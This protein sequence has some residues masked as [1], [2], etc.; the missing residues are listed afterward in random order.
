MKGPSSSCLAPDRS[1]LLMCQTE[2]M[3]AMRLAVLTVL[4]TASACGG[5]SQAAEPF[6]AIVD[7]VPLITPDPSGTFAVVSVSTTVD[8]VCAVAY[9]E[10]TELGRL[11][12]DLDMAG[13]GHVDHSARLTGLTPDSLYYYR[14]QGVGPD[15][16]LFQSDLMEFRT[17]PA[18]AT[19]RNNVAPTGLVVDVSSEFS[20][21]FAAR[22]AIDGDP[23]TEWS[24][25]GDG[26]GAF[27]VIDLG[28]E[29]DIVGVAFRARTMSDGSAITNTF[30][31]IVDEGSP[32]GPF[33]AGEAELAVTGRVVR[34]D[35]ESSTGGN[36]GAAE[37]EIYTNR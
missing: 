26:D 23:G 11:A 20:T 31:V 5:S 27:I 13:G 3:R 24:S 25:Q 12:T 33:A 10:T 6:S 30:S 16:T 21:A 36:T 14:L 9:G 29:T 19:D 28:V 18:Q 32:L 15:G 7:G 2:P 34:F 17:P 1:T 37:V 35:V 4:I 22:L 8:A